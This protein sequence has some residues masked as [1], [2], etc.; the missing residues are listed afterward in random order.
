MVCAAALVL[1]ALVGG[2]SAGSDRSRWGR[3]TWERLALLA[4]ATVLVC[5]VVTVSTSYR[6]GWDPVT[7]QQVAEGTREPNSAIRYFSVY[8]NILPM[9]MIGKLAVWLERAIGLDYAAFFAVVAV[10]S[11][12]VTLAAGLVWLARRGA[13]P[14]QAAGFVVLTGLIVG[15]SPWMGVPYTDLV[16]LPIPLLVVALL[17]FL[18]GLQSPRW[19]LLVAGLA[20]LVGIGWA[21]KTTPIVLLAAVVVGVLLAPGDRPQWQR[22]SAGGAVVALALAHPAGLIAAAKPVSDLP[23]RRVSR[24]TRASTS[25]PGCALQIYA[26]GRR[27]YGCFDRRL[28][29]PTWVRTLPRNAP[30]RAGDPPA[31]TTRT[32]SPRRVLYA[33]KTHHTWE[34]GCSSPGVRLDME[35]PLQYRLS[36]TRSCVPSARRRPPP[37]S[38]LLSSAGCG[39]GCCSSR[40]SGTGSTGGTGTSSRSPPRSPAWSCS[41]RSSRGAGAMSS[42]WRRCSS[43]WRACPTRTG[44]SPTLRNNP[45]VTLSPLTSTLLHAGPDLDGEAAL[46]WWRTAVIY[47]VYPRS[48]A[49]SDGDGVG[50]LP[51]IIDRLPYLRELGVDALWLSPFYVSPMHDA[52]YDVADYEDVDPIFGTSP[53]PTNSSPPP[54]ARP[55]GHR[56]P[57]PEP[58]RSSTRGSRRRSRPP[59]SQTGPKIFRDGPGPTA[60]SPTDW[61]SA[62]RTCDAGH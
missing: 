35:E 51:G 60:S 7:V 57:R 20:V 43:P 12:A 58:P 24:S 10:A 33:H 62:R 48:W 31:C 16:A 15:I 28:T 13:R 42:S 22:W 37:Q 56:R 49:D 34:T 32:I 52:G 23:L 2:R 59:R 17:S 5:T 11:L 3:R 41:R 29:R 36:P 61:K 30:S 26:D 47:Q 1:I 39:P 50:D 14:V 45:P 9:L 40:R 55:E 8:P 21:V 19:M 38:A 18:P 25:P 4:A 53:T 6:Y 44:P 54:T 27:C 46:P